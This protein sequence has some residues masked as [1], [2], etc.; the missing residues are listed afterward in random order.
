MSEPSHGWVSLQLG[1]LWEYRELMYFLVW[2][3]VKVRYKQT[4]I[5]VFWAI[6]QP[7]MIMVVFTV[8]FGNLA[9]IPSDGI[10]YPIFTYVA[11]L[12]WQ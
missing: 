8:F 10:P 9:K 2:R 3:D 11:L 6:L 12:P 4:A 1:K 5:G 7:F